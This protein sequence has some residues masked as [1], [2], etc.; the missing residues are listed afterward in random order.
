MMTTMMI[1]VDLKGNPASLFP[2][3][4]VPNTD[5]LIVVECSEGDWDEEFDN[6]KGDDDGDAPADAAPKGGHAGLKKLVSSFSLANLCL[7]SLRTSFCF[8]IVAWLR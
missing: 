4:L 5:L 6:D 2:R 1:S 7:P 8:D 3:S